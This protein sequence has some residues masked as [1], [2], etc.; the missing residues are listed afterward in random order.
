[1]LEISELEVGYGGP[2]VLKRVSLR[3]VA[4]E[5]VGI[6][7]AN[8]AGKTTLVRAICGLLE[9]SSGRVVKDEMDVGGLPP[10]RRV[11]LGIAAVLE[12]RH[13]FGEMTIEQ[14]LALA[15]AYGRKRS[16]TQLGFNRGDVLGLFPFMKGRLGSA[17]ELLSG[18]EQ[19]MVAIAKA[20][21][22]QPDVLIMDE[23]STGLAPLV[24]KEIVS[25]LAALKARGMS[26]ILV[27][28][29][30]ALAAEISDRGYVMAVGEVVHE[31]G[32]GEWR[33]FLGDERLVQAYLG[34]S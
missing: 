4:N 5:T 12:N 8:G 26:I 18:G 21:L 13:L 34:E 29:N 2:P 27:E 25:V 30:V 6:I 14:H 15:E 33:E 16:A 17:A 31:I 19:Q 23:P 24:V 9:P 10:H 11:L 1:M 7:G 20:L 28:Q 3:A 32:V 22:L